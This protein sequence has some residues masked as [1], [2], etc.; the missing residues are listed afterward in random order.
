MCYIYGIQIGCIFYIEK[1]TRTYTQCVQ[2]KPIIIVPKA[3][4]ANPAFLKAAGIARIPEPSDDFN[5]CTRE[6]IVLKTNTKLKS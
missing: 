5:K 3:P 2:I 1:L 6:P 4:T